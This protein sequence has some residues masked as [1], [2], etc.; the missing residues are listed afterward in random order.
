MRNL[1][2]ELNR[3]ERRDLRTA[4]DIGRGYDYSS[5][6][7][8]LA[9]ELSLRHTVQRQVEVLCLQDGSPHKHMTA[10]RARSILACARRGDERRHAE[11]LELLGEAALTSKK[12]PKCHFDRKSLLSPMS[13]VSSPCGDSMDI[14]HLDPFNYFCEHIKFNE[15]EVAP[16]TVT[17]KISIEEFLATETKRRQAW[18]ARSF[19]RGHRAGRRGREDP[20]TSVPLS[21]AHQIYIRK[22]ALGRDQK[23]DLDISNIMDYVD[24]I[25]DDNL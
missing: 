25:E 15:I 21:R 10:S 4:L 14:N 7:D 5:S 23:I 1:T 19:G 17:T 22:S 11:A 9:Q 18:N 6:N 16:I 24:E 20:Y 12:P 3:R 13:T 8:R 2:P